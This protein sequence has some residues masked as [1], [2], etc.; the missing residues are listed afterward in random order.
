MHDSC[1]FKCI[2]PILT[3]KH[4]LE[5]GLGVG[6]LKIGI[7]GENGVKTRNYCIISQERR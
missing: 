6:D 7:L 2:E 4:F 5:L 1:L 3:H